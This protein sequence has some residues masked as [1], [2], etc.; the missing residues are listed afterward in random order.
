MDSSTA[1]AGALGKNQFV[2]LLRLLH[3]PGLSQRTIAER[4]GLS[5]GTVNSSVRQLVEHGDLEKDAS[6]NLC[7]TDLGV[8]S[9]EPYRVDNAIILA[10]GLSTRFAP[11][12]YEKPKGLLRVRRG[13]HRT[14]D[15]PA[16]GG[17]HRR[18]HRRR[19]LQE[20]VLLLSGGAL[21]R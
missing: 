3:E 20:G 12:S 5:V 1:N 2:V 6:G 14:P 4:T 18:Y 9:L 19:G 10:A 13:P 7:V 21:W 17:G 8:R 15:S 11:I 16:Q